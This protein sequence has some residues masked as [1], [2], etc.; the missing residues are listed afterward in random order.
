MKHKKLTQH[1]IDLLSR[2]ICTMTEEQQIE[3]LLLEANAY[4][5]RSEVQRC[6]QLSI[7]GSTIL[8]KYQD[9]YMNVI[10]G[11]KKNLNLIYG[12]KKNAI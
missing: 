5:L 12:T 9:A 3:E 10:Y 8:D 4:G 1:K 6:A 11:T 7:W 2:Q